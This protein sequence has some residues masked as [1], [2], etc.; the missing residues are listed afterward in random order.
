M[1]HSLYLVMERD[2]TGRMRDR[3]RGVNLNLRLPSWYDNGAAPLNALNLTGFYRASSKLRVTQYMRHL[4]KST[5]RL[6]FRVSTNGRST[7]ISA[8]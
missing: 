3:I 5:I 6:I 8:A 7:L 4:R 1:C 2:L